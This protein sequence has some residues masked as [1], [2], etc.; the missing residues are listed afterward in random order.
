MESITLGALFFNIFF[1]LYWL[2]Y[3]IAA[4]TALYFLGNATNP[5][6]S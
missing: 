1:W 2:V 5:T 4:E 6:V 3:S